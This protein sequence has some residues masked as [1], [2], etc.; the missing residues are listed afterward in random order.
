M[1]SF[2]LSVLI[3][4]TLL[5]Q[6]VMPIH[7][8]NRQITVSC[9]PN[10]NRGYDF[11]Y[12]KA[13]EGSFLVKIKLN[14][15]VNVNE[16]EYKQVV[17]SSSG[18]LLSVN[19]LL[20]GS[21]VTFAT[22]STSYLRG[23]PN[24]KIDTSF[25]YAL[26]YKKANTFSI[27][28][29]SNLKEKYFGN[30]NTK[31][32][33]A[34]QFSST[35]CDTACAIRKG[36][37][38]AVCDKYVMDTSITKTYT[39]NIN[40]VLI[41]QPDGT[42]A[43]YKGFKKG[44]IFV[45]EGQTVLPYTPLGTLAHY[46]SNK[47]YSLHLMVYYLSDTNIEMSNDK[48]ITLKASKNYYNYIDPLFI[49]DKGVTR[50]MNWKNFTSGFSEYVWE[51]EMSNRELK[52]AGK[53]NKASNNLVRIQNGI[54]KKNIKQ[55]KDTTYFDNKGNEVAS[56]AQ[57]SEI[58]VKWIDP[59]NVHKLNFKTYFLSNKLKSEGYYID[60]PDTLPAPKSSYGYTE[61]ETGKRWLL[62]GNFKRWYE[63]GQLQRDV[64]F[65][66]G[67]LN[68][69]VVTYWDNG[70]VKRTNVDEKGGKIAGKCFDRDGKEVPYYPYG[71]GAQFEDGKITVEEYVKSKIIYPEEALDKSLQGAVQVVFN[72]QEDGTVGNIKTLR[73]TDP[74]FENEL[75]RVIKD[76][77][78]WKPATMDG[79]YNSF[80]YNLTHLFTLP[81]LKIDWNVKLANKDTTFY[82]KA[83]RIVTDNKSAEY[84]EILQP[85]PQNPDRVLEQTF[86]PS[87]KKL[88]E[89]YFLKSILSDN[90]QDSVYN[91]YGKSMLP[92]GFINKLTRLPEGKYQEWHENGQLSKE[93]N[94]QSGIK[95]GQT[96]MYWNNGKQRRNDLFENGVL[97]SGNC[98]DKEGRTVEYFDMDKKA[99]F[100]GGKKA[101]IEYLSS[102][103]KYPENALKNKKEG[104]VEVK[105]ILS[106]SGSVSKIW[107][108]KS[109]DKELDKEAIRLIMTMPKWYPEFKDGDTAQ[110]LQTLKI[111]FVL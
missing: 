95:T 25:V 56:L 48:P 36:L 45:T 37:V 80:T 58:G 55:E 85:D 78:K 64:N 40:S 76:M 89:K 107:I 17:R 47:T 69:K 30:I 62:H 23:I 32:F 33:K 105:F 111:Q 104:T 11:S 44:S 49:T 21:S 15:A 26:P 98:F 90:S 94:Y 31:N 5:L 106:N 60:K 66:N 61:K 52:A 22:Y 59:D 41:E 86:Y 53:K 101:L 92:Q 12:D 14:N 65:R 87:N 67:A 20:K 16:T 51:H 79:D 28:Y 7:S 57:A 68:G 4:C 63:T 108:P 18:F 35:V 39:S 82:N 34:F 102:N 77:P 54:E 91:K 83:G 27:N 43:L 2:K 19:P 74:L 10:Q 109:V 103:I 71:K 110:S 42:L 81:K 24:P 72:I 75:K 84:Y 93:I 13:V 50:L 8:Q 96:L 100:V 97:I 9:V 70:K 1:Q 3:L 38:V 99:S 6:T 46:D 29:L 88:S 73:S